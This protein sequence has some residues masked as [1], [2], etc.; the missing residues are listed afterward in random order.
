MKCKTHFM[1]SLLIGVLS[2]LALSGCSSSSQVSGDPATISEEFREITLRVP[3]DNASDVLF[4]HQ[5]HAEQYLGNE[6]LTCHSHTGIRDTTIWNCNNVSCHSAG[7]TEGLCVDD[8]NDHAC[9]MKQCEQCHVTLSPDP[10][11]DCADC[12]LPVNTG[13]FLDSPVENLVYTTETKKGFTD[14]NGTFRYKPDETSITF[15]IGDIVIGTGIPKPVMTPIDIVPGAVDHTDQGVTNISRFLQTLDEDGVHDNGVTIPRAVLNHVNNRSVDFSAPDDTTFENDPDLQGFLSDL[16]ANAVFPTG[17]RALIDPLTAQNNLFN[18]LRQFHTPPVAGSVAM[19]GSLYVTGNVTGTYLYSDVD[20]DLE[21]GSTY[22]W[23]LDADSNPGG[24]TPIPSATSLTYSPVNADLNNYLVFEV[25]PADDFHQGAPARSAAIGPV[26]ADPSN[27]S[28]TATCGI[29]GLLHR[30]FTLAGSYIYNDLEG[31]PEGSSIIQWYRDTDASPG[32]EVSISGAN[33]FA[34]APA[35]ADANQYLVFEV[36]PVAVSGQSP[37]QP[38][39]ERVGPIGDE[40]I[41][42]MNAGANQFWV[43]LND[44]T[45]IDTYRYSVFNESSAF[46]NVTID[47]ESAE[48]KAGCEGRMP[49]GPDDIFGD[50]GLCDDNLTTNFYLFNDT[51]T[52]DSASL[53]EFRDC[54]PPWPSGTCG[55]TSGC[56]PGCDSP[57]AFNSR[58]GRNPYL[59][60]DLQEGSYVLKI[61]AA[62]LD[63][64]TNALPDI[65]QDSNSNGVD[66]DPIEKYRYKITFTFTK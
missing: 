36:T 12:H 40:T 31:D 49:R 44:N 50:G 24:E 65:Q 7:D 32:G 45:D 57:G 25:T 43:S 18:T 60:K 26:P 62:N 38:C 30:G 53:I 61:G 17:S 16:N 19:T 56:W 8:D 11:A 27:T 46:T 42:I 58:S 51:G 9:W 28:P 5:T 66:Y 34:Y 10:T 41:T 47:I 2:V 23:Y 52:F 22:Q 20:G 29:T 37:G 63:R 14:S 39:T 13:V 1:K 3:S 55:S 21:S 6:C 64:D 48:A 4:T 35:A 33:S 15:S 59:N 54:L